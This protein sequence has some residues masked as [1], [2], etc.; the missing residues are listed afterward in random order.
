MS[1]PKYGHSDSEQVRHISD[2]SESGT[3]NTVLREEPRIAQKQDGGS[4]LCVS[5]NSGSSFGSTGFPSLSKGLTHTLASESLA[6]RLGNSLWDGNEGTFRLFGVP[7]EAREGLHAPQ[8]GFVLLKGTVVRR[9]LLGDKFSG[10]NRESYDATA[11]LFD[12]RNRGRV[13]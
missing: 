3:R 2:D 9:G 5:R 8:M 11:T 13:V 4:Q 1:S 6:E 10:R 12:E 7:L